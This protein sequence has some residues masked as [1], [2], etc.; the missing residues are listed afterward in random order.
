[1]S[2]PFIFL[3][4]SSQDDDF[5]RL[6][7]RELSDRG[8]RVW[9]DAR[10]LR[11][12]DDLNA[13]IK[14]AISSVGYFISILS[15][16]AVN[17]SWVLD[18]L[19]W[20]KAVQKKRPD[21]RIIP[22]QLPEVGLALIRFLLGKE[23]LTI[24][25]HSSD[26]AGLQNA[27]PDILTALGRRLP[28]DREEMVSPPEAAVDRLMLTLKDPEI[29]TKGG[30][31]RG[32]AE[33]TL[34]FHSAKKGVRPVQSSRFTFIS[35]LGP[36][37]AGDL[38]WYI[39]DYPGHPF[40]FYEERAQ[41]IS[42][43]LAVWGHQLYQAITKSESAGKTLEKWL[44]ADGAEERRFSIEIDRELLEDAEP[45]AKAAAHEAASN[46][47]SLPWEIL[48]DGQGF[49]FQGR[50][51]ARVRRR[52]PNRKELEALPLQPVLRI[53]LL[54]PRPVEEGV[55]FIDHRISPRAL[56]DAVEPLGKLAE[57]TILEQPTFP[58][59]LTALEE[60]QKMGKP[61]TVVHFD[62]HGVFDRVNGL[63][64]LCFESTEDKEQ[65]KAYD[66]K[67]ELVHADRIA[68]ELRGYR[69]PLF[70]LDACQTAMTQL[71]PTASVAATLLE[72]GVAS[73]AAMSHSVL[74]ETAKRF[75]TEFYRTLATGS[76]IGTAMLAGQKA[77][78]A[79]MHRADLPGGKQLH[80]QDWF[81]P[82]LYQEEEDP[83]IVKKI[84]SASVIGETLAGRILRRGALPAEPPHTFVGRSR[85]LLAAE[86][87][88][89]QHPWLVI[90]G[91]GGAGK[92]T[93]ATELS[94][95][96]LRTGRCEQV[97][98][99]SFE[100]V[101]DA[102]AALDVLGR[103]VL[104]DQ[105]DYS[106]AK[107]E[108]EAAAF[109]PVARALK[110][111]S[112][113]IL[114]DN[115]ESIL[116]LSDGEP[117]LGVASIDDFIAF[118]EKLQQTA[119]YTRL[120]FTTR[121]S[122]PAPFDRGERELRLGALGEY[123]AV[124][125][126]AQI[127]R[128]EGI[129][130]PA[131]DHQTL[132]ELFRDLVEKA[133]YH[134]RALTLLAREIAR[135][136]GGL[137]GLTAELHELM[138]ELDRRHPGERENSLFASVE[139]SLRRLPTEMREVVNALA[140][141][142][143]GA[144][145]A[146]WA[147]VAEQEQETVAQA[148]MALV[149]VGLA[150]LVL[151]RFPYFFKIDPALPVHLKRQMDAAVLAGFEARWVE[152]TVAL[153]KFLYAQN[154]KDVHL[155]ASL[156]LLSE[157]NLLAML[158]QKATTSSAE[159]LV[160]LAERVES[161]FQ[162]LA[163]PQSLVH[164]TRIREVA[165]EKL[166]EWSNARFLTESATIDRLF[167]KGQIRQALILA[168]K[169]Y[170]QCLAAGETAYPGAAYDTAM[171]HA[172][173]GRML[174]AIGSAEAALPLLEQARSHFLVLAERDEAAAQMAAKCLPD[175]GDC[176]VD[177]GKLEDAA[178]K[179][180]QAVSESEKLEDWRTVAVGKGQLADVR[181]MQKKFDETVNLYKEVM[182]IFER[183]GEEGSVAIIW[184]QIGLT[185]QNSGQVEQAEK[186]YLR[187]LA[188][189]TRL[190]NSANEALTLGQL[191]N[192]YYATQRLEDAVS[193]YRRAA[194]I[195][196][197]LRDLRWEGVDR[198]N[199]ADTLI[200]LQRYDEA[201]HEIRKAIECNSQLGAAAVPWKSWN[202]LY[203]LES[204]TGQIDAAT[205]A[206]RKAITSYAAYREQGGESQSSYYHFFTA[207]YHAIR[208]G[209]TV[210]ALEQLKANLTPDAPQYYK[211]IIQKLL[212]VLEGQRD[213]NL[214]EDPNLDYDDVVELRL[215]L[216]QLQ[217]AG[218]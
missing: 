158:T 179:Y 121:E 1:M 22:L 64:A 61:F 65:R 205:E 58:A 16:A 185:H 66:R 189:K 87:L 35:P 72:N 80:L 215:L 33:A 125:L 169:I 13:A 26:G 29:Y 147:M 120:I 89:R 136:R 134:A 7:R 137:R 18:E 12:G 212:V 86:R 155:A 19:Q 97:A 186:A 37:E 201:R 44:A 56:L 4:H 213:P 151:D 128:T 176:L 182:D 49:L 36:I 2:T 113:I 5:V 132:K 27:L 8:L 106:V 152:G 217:E 174:T 11:G 24:P 161:L 138:A 123:D 54:S 69:I 62:G 99:V 109:Q 55:G 92:T 88:L 129:Q 170:R 47:L 98:F 127:M 23:Q 216:K 154:S 43:N 165:A 193:M 3:S 131:E 51:P 110:E 39:E 124:K 196:V 162:Y 195:H 126:V 141:Y 143:G 194:E 122:L 53:L 108:N 10:Q 28:D 84:P 178:D 206:R 175:I 71:D 210:I 187:S 181:R 177:I 118:F 50:R 60:A 57:L 104:P 93:L 116:P 192:L 30:V 160:Q 105:P 142:H 119:A 75:T 190:N 46:L 211:S 70:F 95:W 90:R 83:Q 40:D 15:P 168:E 32:K 202:I 207:T 59:L 183:L 6:L 203:N 9:D 77:L 156:T 191:G 94:R 188:I 145:V 172:R 163:R 91:Q 153:A 100:E 85:D 81:V 38:K 17:S 180:L 34:V 42:K 148:G 209:E 14:S 68:A 164:A 184:H 140:V 218:L 135:H 114:L 214:A 73:V 45:E 76:R 130:L 117:L 48:H 200:K 21:Y 171:A 52:L 139:L 20:A 78:H 199:L 208:S 101:K 102:R 115:L 103:Q 111:R 133:N 144:D 204:A 157:A 67:M 166:G 79:D 149:Q 74:V 146:T 41:E 197:N 159:E 63:G 25:I 107:Y 82:V 96:L 31:T 198:S 167:E 112:T 173:L 150:E